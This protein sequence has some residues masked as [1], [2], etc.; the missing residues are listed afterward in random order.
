MRGCCAAGARRDDH[1]RSKKKLRPCWGLPLAT[2]KTTHHDRCRRRAGATPGLT[3]SACVALNL[4]RAS[5]YRQRWAFGEAYGHASPPA[6]ATPRPGCRRMSNRAEPSARTAL[7]RSGA[8]RDLCL[9]ADEGSTTARSA[10][11]TASWLPA[12]RS[13]AAPAAAHPVY[14]KPELL[15]A[16]AQRGLV[17][18]ITK[19]M[20]PRQWSYFY[21]YVI[22]DIFSRRVVGWCVA[23]RESATCSP[24]CSRTPLPNIP[25]R[26]ASSLC[27]PT[28]AVRCAPRP[29][30]SCSPISVVTKS[31]S[32][33][34]TSN[35]NPFSEVH[36]KTMKY[37]RSFRSARLHPGRKG[38]LSLLLR[39][40]NQ[41]HHHAASA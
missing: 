34:H 39:W 5:V 18:D 10:P 9:P 28:V 3:A 29:R 33:P 25:R 37:H 26:K 21:L 27:T 13:G 11:C 30:H 2:D 41:D 4:S 17:M 16:G 24:R 20:G 22:I 36:F 40:Y 38:L 31:H 15:C 6:E 23:D 35:D 12:R 7:R 8:R 19:L 14:K 1:L 32:R